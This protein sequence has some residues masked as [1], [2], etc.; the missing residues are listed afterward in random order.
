MNRHKVWL[1]DVLWILPW[2]GPKCLH[3]VKMKAKVTTRQC[4]HFPTRPEF[5]SLL[6]QL[7]IRMTIK[8][9]LSLSHDLCKLNNFPN[10][11]KRGGG[12]IQH[13]WSGF[14]SWYKGQILSH[15]WTTY[16]WVR[17]KL[18]S[19][20][21]WAFSVLIAICESARYEW[22]MWLARTCQTII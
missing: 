12:R 22:W 16:E 4:M 14:Y 17:H 20:Q 3:Q 8:K 19:W 18:W 7:H 2:S 10:R 1:K 13:P 5:S 21:V 15:Q 6:K 9:T 11:L